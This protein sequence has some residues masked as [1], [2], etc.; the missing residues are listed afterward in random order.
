MRISLI[1][2]GNVGWHLGH[3]LA[4]CGLPPAQVYSRNPQHAEELS[5]R[6]ASRPISHLEQ[7]QPHC[8]LYLLAIRDDAIEEVAGKLA[9]LLPEGA[10]VAHT[11]GATP[12]QVLAPY[13][14]HWG[15]FYPLQTFSRSSPVDFADVP[16]CV[17]AA[18]ETDEALLLK[19]GHRLSRMV[20]VVHDEARALLHLAAVFVN[21]FTNALYALGFELTEERDLDVDLLRPLILETA[22][23][24]M[25]GHPLNV[26]TG[27]ARRH[28]Q[29]TME[30]HLA[31]LEAIHPDYADLYRRLTGLI[32]NQQ[33]KK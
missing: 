20:R 9:T 7:V 24:V 4:E 5:E 3:R 26:Q 29:T 15:V 16:L 14:T 17:Y 21:N 1:G 19:L 10:L 23:K 6:I 18:S 31:Y 13:F 28:D 32:Q 2:A 33:S 12:G 8:D 22:R 25:E 27:P 30:R 11:S